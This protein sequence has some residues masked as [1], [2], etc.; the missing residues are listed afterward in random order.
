MIN[1]AVKMKTIWEENS[2]RG[3]RQMMQPR[4]SSEKG[5]KL[6]RCGKSQMEF[7]VEKKNIGKKIIEN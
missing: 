2:R 6:Y 3:N 7:D 1:R 4:K 5:E